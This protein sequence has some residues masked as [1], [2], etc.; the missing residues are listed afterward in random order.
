[1]VV[2][3]AVQ[4][5]AIG[6][7]PHQSMLL[8]PAMYA[9]YLVA[10]PLLILATPHVRHKLRAIVSHFQ[11]AGLVG[12]QDRHPFVANIA[13]ILRWRDSRA[14]AVVIVVL[15][16]AKAVT[17]GTFSVAEMPDS[18]RVLET[19]GHRSL[20]LAG[21]WQ[22][23]VCDTLYNIM[24]LLLL[25]R[26]ALLWRFFWKTSRMDLRLNAAH[27]DGAGGLAF[28]GILLPAFRL[29]LFAIAASAAGALANLI[30]HTG[31]SFAD[32]RY[33]IAAFSLGLVAIVAGP[34]L[35]FNG[36]LRRVKQ[37]A[38]LACGALAGRQLKVFEE[39][40]LGQSPPDAREMLQ[41][42]D[43][44]AAGDLMLM[45]STARKMHTLPFWPRQL[46]PL[47]AAALLPFV[48]VAAMQIPLKEILL[49]VL[50]LVR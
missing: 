29:P 40:W 12:E 26:L 32:F 43:F 21:W 41:A 11:A 14:A 20:S 36:Q 45:V 23:A 25:Y 48:P 49:R 10:L 5:R 50:K 31:A 22:F 13:A 38:G 27:P 30:L 6:P 2:L 16:V 1:L 37:Q 46:V 19:G 4:G 9:R 17:V 47:V 7:S 3:A 35:F 18:W 8:D 39:K 44:S 33:A 15:A 34:L 24:V 42:P 28:L